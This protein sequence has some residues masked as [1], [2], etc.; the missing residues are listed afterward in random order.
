MTQRERNWLLVA[1]AAAWFL[2]MLVLPLTVVLVF[3]FGE[4]GPAGGYVPA[5]TLEQYANLPAR[6]HR[7]Q[8]HADPGAARHARGAADRLSA[9]LLA[10]GAHRSADGRR[11]LLVLVIV[12]F[13]TSILIRSYAW[14][15][16]LGGRGLAGAA[17]AGR[18]RGCAADQHALRGAGRHRLRLPAADG[19]SDLRQPRPARQAPARSLVRPWRAAVRDLPAG[20]PAAVDPGRRDRLHAG[21]HPADGRIPDPG[22]AGRRQGVLRRQRAGRSVP[23][24]A[25]LGLR[26]GR[27]GD[28]GRDHAGDRHALHAAHRAG[29]APGA[30]TSR[31]CEGRPMR[32]YAA[33][34][35]LFLYTPIAI[36]ALFSFNAGR[37]ASQL[38]GF[39]VQ[40]YGRA[41]DQ[42][43]RDGRAE[44]Q[45]DRGLRL[46]DARQRLRHDGRRRPAGHP[47]PGCAR[48][49]TRSSTSR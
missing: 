8:E 23:A 6:L 48:S 1:P 17:R 15:F 29:S 42:P 24:I 12:P 28:A 16:I 26:L 10:G 25:Q 41:L 13:W 36:I 33:C 27:G 2:V 21:L 39:S 31:S 5:F 34:V 37:H 38:Q 20:H 22:A 45:P 18:H 49:S 7:L 3:S 44:D 14:I 40:W 46:G 30:K 11:M 4:R 35:Y 19:L 32:I 9:G 47:R 43:L